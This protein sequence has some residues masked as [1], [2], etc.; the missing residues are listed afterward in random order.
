MLPVVVR[1]RPAPIM[2]NNTLQRDEEGDVTDRSREAKR[3]SEAR[4]RN[5]DTRI[6]QMHATMLQ[7]QEQIRL[8]QQE[9]LRQLN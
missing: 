6:A 7:Q 9:M 5:Q 4:A 1:Q 3:A 2:T 8:R